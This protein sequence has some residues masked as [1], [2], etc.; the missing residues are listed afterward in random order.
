[1]SATRT[2]PWRS[3][4]RPHPTWYWTTYRS[5]TEGPHAATP[6]TT[7][8]LLGSTGA[9]KSTLV[10]LIPRFYDASSG[11]IEVGGHD[12]RAWAQRAL[13][14]RVG[15]VPQDSLLFSGTVRDNIRYG[16]PEASDAEVERAARA[17]QAHEFI[18]ALDHAY[19][20]HVEQRGANFSGGQ[21]QRIA[22]ARAL[23]VD[24][25]ILSLRRC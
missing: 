4:S 11:R 2:T 10:H 25:T 17:A 15:I 19:D 12:V 23:L 22:I 8:A 1:M 14:A 6:G 9:G 21:K 16:R 13:V 5:R 18:A 24:P 7:V 20:S 3:Q